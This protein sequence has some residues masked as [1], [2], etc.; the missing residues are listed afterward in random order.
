ME[1]IPE[2]GEKEETDETD[3]TGKNIRLFGPSDSEPTFYGSESA[4][5][6]RRGLRPGSSLRTC[7]EAIYTFALR[8]VGAG[9]L[10]LRRRLLPRAC[11]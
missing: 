8:P 2:K 9:G 6:G 1:L 10:Y 5:G 3:E 7:V 11:G 4:R